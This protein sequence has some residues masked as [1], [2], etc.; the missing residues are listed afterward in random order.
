MG[1]LYLLPILIT[2]FLPLILMLSFHLIST[3]PASLTKL[4]TFI[5][6]YAQCF[7]S[8]QLVIVCFNLPDFGYNYL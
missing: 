3:V 4:H 2:N 6:F 5:T 8:Y 1:L 7:S